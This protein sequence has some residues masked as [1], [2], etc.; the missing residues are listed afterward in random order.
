MAPV[1]SKLVLYNLFLKSLLLEERS[2]FS[3]VQFVN[4]AS[5]L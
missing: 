3:I 1:D 2:A 5:L 4:K